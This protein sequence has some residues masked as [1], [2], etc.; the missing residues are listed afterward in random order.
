VVAAFLAKLDAKGVDGGLV[1]IENF[2]ETLCDLVRLLG[3]LDTTVLDAF[4]PNAAS[5]RQAPN[6]AAVADFLP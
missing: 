1:V 4:P 5:G 3:D 6:L 2:D